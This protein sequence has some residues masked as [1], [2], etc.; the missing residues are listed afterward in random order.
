[1]L[2]QRIYNYCITLINQKIN[3]MKTELADLTKGTANDSK[4]SAGDKHETAQAMMQLE[5]EKINRR[6][7]EVLE[8][9]N[10]LQK[11]DINI[12]S[13]KIIIGS[14]VKT[15]GLYLFISVAL[16]KIN[17]DDKNII[18]LS[19]DSPLGKKLMGLK[20]NER[21][22]INGVVYKIEEIE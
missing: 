18:F 11:I 20:I 4:S 1:M 16:G 3:E 14:L 21:T 9:K 12:K 10:A 6:L 22:E 8:Q 2:K 5:Q 15:N 17:M 7:H 13:S 19:P